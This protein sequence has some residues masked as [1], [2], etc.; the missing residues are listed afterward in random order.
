MTK[1]WLRIISILEIVG[2]IFGI[3]ILIWWFL[4]S[5]FNIYSLLIA[6][7]PIAICIFSILAGYWLWIGNRFGRT[8]SIIVQ[9]IQLPKIFSSFVIFMFSFGFDVWVQFLILN[10]GLSNFGVEFR[11]LAFNQLFFNVENAPTGVGIS[12]TALIFLMMLINYRPEV[13]VEEVESPPQPP[14]FEQNHNE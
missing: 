2:G 6:P 1:T 8:A 9:A 14:S 4:V 11:F 12:I 10:N 13:F 7:I 5:P 3:I